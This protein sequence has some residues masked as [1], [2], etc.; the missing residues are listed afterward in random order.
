MKSKRTKVVTKRP[1]GRKVVK[2]FDTPVFERL[3]PSG[4][5]IQ[6]IYR[7]KNGYGA[8]VVRLDMPF[9]G[10]YASYTSNENEWELAVVKFTHKTKIHFD[11]DYN[12]GITSDVM[13]HL[14]KPEVEKVLQKIASLPHTKKIK[15][16]KK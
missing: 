16:V 6:K 9:G 4:R 5:G 3:H 2:L 8:S 11:L 1:V 13:G 7:F 14:T 10:G 12:T 15:K